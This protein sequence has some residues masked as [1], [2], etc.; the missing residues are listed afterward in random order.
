VLL[1]TA[2]NLPVPKS[3]KKFTG[4]CGTSNFTSRALLYETN[5][6]SHIDITSKFPL[7]L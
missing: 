7:D 3:A 2:I 4:V 1:N 5:N 6:I